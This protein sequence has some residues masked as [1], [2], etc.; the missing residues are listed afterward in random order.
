MYQITY[1]D[2]DDVVRTFNL[3]ETKYNLLLESG[4]LDKLDSVTVV[5]LGEVQ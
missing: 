4:E 5:K 3:C 1:T 2:G